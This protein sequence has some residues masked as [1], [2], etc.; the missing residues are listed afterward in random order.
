MKYIFLGSALAGACLTLGACGGG[1]PL[2]SMTDRDQATLERY[3]DYAGEPVDRFTYLGRFDGWQPLSRDK[4]VVWTGI[5]QAYLLTVAQPCSD[6]QFTNNVAVTST[7][8]TVSRGFDSV[9]TRQGNCQIL[10]I[11]P[12]DYLQMKRDARAEHAAAKGSSR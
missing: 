8:G 9:R 11:R 4:L 3:M 2:H 1:I 7:A 5:N 12:V 6:L 10:D